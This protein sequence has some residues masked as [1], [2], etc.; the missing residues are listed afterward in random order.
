MEKID[1]NVVPKQF[2]DRQV[3]GFGKDHFVIGMVCG[4]NLT[5]F[6]LGR[7]NGKEFLQHLQKAVE[8]SEELFGPIEVSSGIKSPVELLSQGPDSGNADKK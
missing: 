2:S 5:T 7:T 3:F 6:A 1:L 8:K 4:N